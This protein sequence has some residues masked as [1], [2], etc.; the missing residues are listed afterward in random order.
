LQTPEAPRPGQIIYL[1]WNGFTSSLYRIKARQRILLP[2]A[3]AEAKARPE[4]RSVSFATD[5]MARTSYPD[6]P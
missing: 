2:G 4:R 5:A 6:W 1:P 3:R